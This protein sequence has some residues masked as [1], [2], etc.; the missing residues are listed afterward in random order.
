MGRSR[1]GFRNRW[2]HARPEHRPS[3][4]CAADR[5]PSATLIFASHRRFPPALDIPIDCRRALSLRAKTPLGMSRQKD[6]LARVERRIRAIIEA[7][8]DGL[9]TPGTKEELLPLEA[10][11]VELAAE[12]KAAP[13]QVQ[14]LHPRL[15]DLSRDKVERPQKSLNTEA[16]CGEAAE[17][18]RN[19]IDEIRL[20]PENGQLQI[21]LAGDLAGVLAL[22]A[23]SKKP[24]TMDRDGLQ[25]TLV[26][27]TCSHR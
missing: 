12:L 5:T 21:E 4:G 26:A 25:V 9:R 27:G 19:L 23:G 17:A 24:V 2:R 15:A 16:T 13:P 14:R 18:L 8:K 20:V 1:G 6:E 10:C 7:I 11:K 3:T 22:T